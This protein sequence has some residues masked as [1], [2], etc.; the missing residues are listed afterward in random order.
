VRRQLMT[1]ITSID[2]AGDDARVTLHLER[3]ASGS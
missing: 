1:G 2:V 3:D